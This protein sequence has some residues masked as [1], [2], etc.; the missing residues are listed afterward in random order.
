MAKLKIKTLYREN[1][2]LTARLNDITAAMAVM[3]HRNGGSIKLTKTELLD[4]PEATF[5]V[6][7]DADFIE[8]ILKYA[9]TTE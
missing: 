4:L 9:E 3:A 1:Q 2:I 7:R 6:H 8:L 5:S